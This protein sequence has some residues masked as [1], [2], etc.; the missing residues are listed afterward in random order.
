M[1]IVKYFYEEPVH[2][3]AL[4]ADVDPDARR[5]AAPLGSLD[6]LLRPQAYYRGYLAGSDLARDRTGATAL[7]RPEAWAE[8][9]T[10]ALS[11]TGWRAVQGEEVESVQTLKEALLCP[12]GTAV[13]ASGSPPEEALREAA[14]A[15]RRYAIPALRA[16]LDGGATVL[17]PEPAHDGF[18]WSMFTAEPLKDRLVA[19]FRAHPAARARRFVAPFQRARGEH[20]FYFERWALD[21]PPDW[22]EEVG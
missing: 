7:R 6:A 14:A 15:E 4:S 16:L 12:Q 11:G 22:A 2:L 13:L 1:D 3:E 5:R 20:K 18:D 21:A 17:F 10:E 19:A 9:L 8:P